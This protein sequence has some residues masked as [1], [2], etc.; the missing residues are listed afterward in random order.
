MPPF[1]V[2]YIGRSDGIKSKKL[3][4]GTVEYNTPT[5]EQLAKT[6]R[7]DPKHPNSHVY[8]YYRELQDTDAKHVDWRIKLAGMLMNEAFPQAKEGM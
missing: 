4:N 6:A 1:R 3:P 2:V 7:K 5:A 8:D